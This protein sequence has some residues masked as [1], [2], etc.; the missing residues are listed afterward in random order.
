M[1]RQAVEWME[2]SGKDALAGDVFRWAGW[3]CPWSVSREIPV[4]SAL[5]K[6]WRQAIGFLVKAGKWSDAVHLQIQLIA[7]SSRCC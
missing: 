6:C 3:S 5:L 2:D 7:L 1:Y 4:R